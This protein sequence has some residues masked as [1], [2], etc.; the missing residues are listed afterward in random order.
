MPRRRPSFSTYA[1]RR[2]R[3]VG[4]LLVLLLGSVLILAIT[5][6]GHDPLWEQRGASMEQGA[7][8]PRGDAVYALVRENGN[9]TRLEA[10]SG[11]DGHPLWSTAINATRALVAAGDDGVAVATDFPFAFLY[12][13]QEDGAVRYQIP[14]E[15]VPRAL[16]VEGSRVALALQA[17]ENPVLIVEGDRVAQTHRF[18]TFVNA[19]DMRGGRVAVGTG[20]GEVVI[21][22][23][24]NGTRLFNGSFAI[25]VK[26][27]RLAGDGA[28]LVFGG[29]SLT[30]GNLSGELTSVDLLSENPVRW[31]KVTPTAVSFVD[32]DRSGVWAVD[33]ENGPEGDVLRAY[34]AYT[35]AQLWAR[36]IDGGLAQGDA[37]QGGGVSLDQ[38]GQTVAVGSLHGGLAAY[39]V[40][41]G[42][43]L[44]SYRVD[45]TTRVRFAG[46]APGIVLV[47]GK[48]TSADTSLG[49]LL[50][51]VG[52]E[53][54]RGRLGALS[55]IVAAGLVAA[56]ALILGV[57]YWRLRRSY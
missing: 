1:R 39:R 16:V 35:G 22:D 31:S 45:G 57:G 40:L 19:L 23:A 44:W 53:P 28:S 11:A 24:L 14:L 12:M 10:H 41:D 6:R 55:A 51:D 2:W 25:A 21:A 18:A 56:G 50:F 5:D 34:E 37:N 43:A 7:V 15:G 9:I 54:L 27:L 36:K 48:R 38:D 52:H 32:L 30:P 8:S 47:N 29:V 26:S 4:I 46:A 49:L 42:H 20:S 3:V 13:I 33:V 17:P